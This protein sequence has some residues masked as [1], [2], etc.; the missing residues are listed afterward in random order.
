MRPVTIV[1]LQAMTCK[2]GLQ[3]AKKGYSY[4]SW[5]HPSS[6]FATSFSPPS[7]DLQD[8]L[9]VFKQMPPQGWWWQQRNWICKPQRW[10]KETNHQKLIWH[11]PIALNSA[12]KTLHVSSQTLFESFRYKGEGST[13]S[14]YMAWTHRSKLYTIACLPTKLFS[15]VLDSS[16]DYLL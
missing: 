3:E 16:S 15:R 10:R 1:L 4:Q 5:S 2:A 14:S 9:A 13:R 11:K 6:P 12:L 7:Q 8:W